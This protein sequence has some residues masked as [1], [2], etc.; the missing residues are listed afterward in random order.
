MR[1]R[2]LVL[3]ALVC[4]AACASQP[5][6]ETNI[7]VSETIFFEGARLIPGDGSPPIM[8]S[9]F[10]VHDGR[11]AEIGKRGELERP[12]GNVAR[13]D[14]TG[15]TVMP[16]L[17]NLHAHP[18]FVKAGE[19][20]P[21]H[22]SRQSIMEDLNRYAYYGVGAILGLGTDAGDLPLQVRTD[23][24][25]GEVE[26]ATYLTVGRGVTAKGGWPTIVPALKGVPYEVTSEEAARNAVQEL[27]GK[28]VDMIKIWVDDRR[29]TTPALTPE[30][31]RT[32]IDEAHQHDVRVMAH[33]FYLADAKDLVKA[34]VDGFA[35]SIQDRE[36]DEE[37][38]S[39]MKERGTFMVPT[40]AVHQGGFIYAE[41]PSWIGEPAMSETVPS[42]VIA[43]LMSEE[44]VTEFRNNPDLEKI[45][46][47][48]QNAQQNLI[49]LSNA[50]VKIGFGTDSGTPNQF[51]GYSEH[52]ELELMVQA[53]LTPQQAI[54]A[55]TH[56]S[57]EILNLDDVGMLAV[58]KSADF[59]VLDADP[60][61]NITNSRRIATV[62]RKAKELDRSSLR[63]YWMGG[64]PN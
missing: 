4:V 28:N 16:L 18:G 49:R 48:Y 26:G 24:A 9:E 20:A 45:R 11:F 7:A 64:A 15:K 27:A 6:D 62:Y 38:I 59:L 37:L 58:G 40:L 1:L 47:E 63:T 56:I 14:L 53:G 46:H 25:R 33:V 55:A 23:Q 29:G 51:V 34:G 61:E 17:I 2:L 30:L 52:R 60:L 21:E 32:I 8:D 31:Y 12:A 35:H 19:F 10:I 44:F 36:I 54:S 43:R 39:L 22:Y 57:A 13:V 42:D 41:R 3:V 5:V 50:G